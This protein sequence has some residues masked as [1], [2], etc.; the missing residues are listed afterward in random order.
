MD[1]PVE[2]LADDACAFEDNKTSFLNVRVDCFGQ[3]YF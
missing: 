3:L 1:I 2:L